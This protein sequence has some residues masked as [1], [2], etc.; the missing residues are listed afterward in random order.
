MTSR[1]RKSALRT[2]GTTQ[3]SEIRNKNERTRS[4]ALT[5]RLLLGTVAVLI[6]GL[7]SCCVAL[8][9]DLHQAHRDILLHWMLNACNVR[10]TGWHRW[11]RKYTIVSAS[12]HSYGIDT[13]A[14]WR[15]IAPA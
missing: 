10:M 4:A 15:V 2:H 12:S 13:S 3:M 11:R 7:L 14:V 5:D 8:H 6:V 9:C 1:K